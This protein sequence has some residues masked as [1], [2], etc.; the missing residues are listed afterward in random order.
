[1]FAGSFLM[2]QTTY[3]QVLGID[4]WT[5]IAGH[6]SPYLTTLSLIQLILAPAPVRSP[7]LMR[8]ERLIDST[9]FRILPDNP[10]LGT[11]V[12]C[13][14]PFT[15]YGWWMLPDAINLGA[16]WHFLVWLLRS[17]IMQVTRDYTWKASNGFCFPR[18][19][20]PDRWEPMAAWV[21]VM[22]FAHLY[23]KW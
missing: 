7:L 22:P 1:M 2:C 19:P 18:L 17:S 9:W 21:K 23:M 11:L 20:D 6:H 3:A 10:S 4:L 15:F 16:A 5:F 12:T 14:L 13:I 8:S